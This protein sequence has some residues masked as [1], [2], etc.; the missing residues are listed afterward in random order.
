[1]QSVG[2]DFALCPNW[3]QGTSFDKNLFR[4]FTQCY[5]RRI[6]KGKYLVISQMFTFIFNHTYSGILF[7]FVQMNLEAKSC[8]VQSN[9]EAV[10]FR[11]PLYENKYSET[12][13]MLGKPSI[14]ANITNSSLYDITSRKR[15]EKKYCF[16]FNMAYKVLCFH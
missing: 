7:N 5:K 6:A 3:K 12:N 2:S 1:M 10:F 11:Y 15:N 13:N 4:V 9:E 16:M 8:S 14:L